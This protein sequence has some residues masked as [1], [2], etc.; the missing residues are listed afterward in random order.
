MTVTKDEHT[1]QETIRL[2]IQQ[3]G[4]TSYMQMDYPNSDCNKDNVCDANMTKDNASVEQWLSL[5]VI[6]ILCIV[7]VL[8]C[9]YELL[10]IK[11]G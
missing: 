11:F 6:L 10:I 4:L 8:W 2:S 3:S 5:Y 7:A 1:V 9:L